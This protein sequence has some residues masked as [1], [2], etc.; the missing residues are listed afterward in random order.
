MAIPLGA[1]D[2]LVRVLERRLL[3]LALYERLPIERRAGVP[4]LDADIAS[5]CQPA[6]SASSDFSQ[7]SVAIT[8]LLDPAQVGAAEGS[9][10]VKTARAALEAVG[11]RIEGERREPSGR[12]VWV[13]R[14]TVND[15]VAAAL[16]PGVV[17]VIPLEEQPAT[18]AP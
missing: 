4:A 18:A 2:V 11:M 17:R 7:S 3:A 10:A 1:R 8:L 12:V 6:A 9:D 15:L 5:L 14:C 16:S 13:G